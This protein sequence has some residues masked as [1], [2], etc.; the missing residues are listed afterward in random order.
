MVNTAG[1]VV[2]LACQSQG[3]IPLIVAQIEVGF[4]PVLRDVD[5]SVLVRIHG[6]RIDVDVGIELEERDLQPAAFQQIADGCRSQPLSER[7]YDTAGHKNQFAHR[8]TFSRHE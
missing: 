7:R 2:V 6:A 4:R 3:G 5:L 8:G 1:G